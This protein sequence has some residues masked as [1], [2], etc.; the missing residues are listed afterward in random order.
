MKKMCLSLCLML[1]AIIF[2]AC[3]E[4]GHSGDNHTN[5]MY[6]DTKRN[7][8]DTNES[9]FTNNRQPNSKY[10]LRNQGLPNGYLGKDI[11][12]MEE[13]PT[14][15]E[16]IDLEKLVAEVESDI[17]N[18]RIILFKNNDSNE[19]VYKSM[20]IKDAAQLTIVELVKD[21]IVYDGTIQ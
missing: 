1:C 8:A 18:K 6:E 10:M 17:P 20:Y 14:I 13:I 19:L 11:A 16:H 4:S 21:Q 9:G 3:M 12:N 5:T 7:V 15:A 2:T